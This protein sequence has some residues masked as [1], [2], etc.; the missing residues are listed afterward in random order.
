MGLVAPVFA[1][2]PTAAGRVKV[3]SGSAF[4]VRGG[5]ELPAR[6]GENVFE[7][8]V[9]RTGADGRLGVTLKDDTR[10]SLGPASDVRVDKFIYAP[11]EGNLALALKIVRGA[12]AYVSGRIAKLSPDAVRL[13]TPA[14]IVGVR[15]TT[16]AIKAD[17]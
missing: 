12:A 16:L 5:T 15:G 4:V 13:E 3:A 6:A 14:A 17:E 1:Q 2:Q 10:V 8:D 9:L 11:S 7:G